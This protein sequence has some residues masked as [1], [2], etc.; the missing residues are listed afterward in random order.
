LKIPWFVL[1]KKVYVDSFYKK[2]KW[3]ITPCRIR[4]AGHFIKSRKIKHQD[5]HALE[6][7]GRDK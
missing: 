6:G 7:C 1:V 5:W 3:E 4:P 2:A